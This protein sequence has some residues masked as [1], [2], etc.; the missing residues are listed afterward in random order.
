MGNNYNN[1]RL[2]HDST[3]T[4]DVKFILKCTF[5]ETFLFSSDKIC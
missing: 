1:G 2:R 4:I 5:L 3:Y